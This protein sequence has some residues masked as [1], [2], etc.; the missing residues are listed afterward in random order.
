MQEQWRTVADFPDYS[1][2][3]LGRVR[4]DTGGKGA[5]VGRI[6]T[7]WTRSGGYLAVKLHRGG[8]H[9][10]LRIHRLVAFAFIGPAPTGAHEVAHFDGV[11]ANN[12][13]NNLRWAT[14][15]ENQ[16]DRVR[17]GTTN[18]G[19]RHWKAKLTEGDVRAIRAEYATGLV[20]QAQ[21]GARYGTCQVNVSD[22]VNGKL[23][24][25]LPD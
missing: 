2:S 7:G 6:M 21:I 22:I 16:R 4:R 18:R 5:T 23:W 17:H 3:N 13:V 15:S 12:H 24:A 1:V 9:K 19:D 11:P 14:R 25:H 10:N 20:T 8:A